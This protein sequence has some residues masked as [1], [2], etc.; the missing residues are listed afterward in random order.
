MLS[1][2]IDLRFHCEPVPGMEVRELDITK[3]PLPEAA[4]A[5]IH[6]T[7]LFMHLA[8]RD[9]VLDRLA[10]PRR[11]PG[12]WIVIEDSDWRA[13]EAQPL[14]QPLAAVAEAMHAGL[15]QRTAWDPNIGTSLLRMF[16]DRGLVDLDVLGEA[17]TM[18]GAD[19]TSTWWTI[20]IEHAAERLVAAGLVDQEQIDG[21]LAIVHSPDFVMMSPLSTQRAGA[22]TRLTLSS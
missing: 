9:A 12:G 13:F 2:D 20:G 1:A 19:Y 18:H 8:D 16:A 6:A 17:R 15:R 11:G 22:P 4:F 5:L 14:P 7:A 3:D 10:S 21:A